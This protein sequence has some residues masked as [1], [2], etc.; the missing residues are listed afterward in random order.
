MGDMGDLFN[1][2]KQRTK[3]HRAEM[4]EKADTT[5]WKQHT[6]YHF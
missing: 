2:M 5:G 3:Q 4:L 1:G 6:Q